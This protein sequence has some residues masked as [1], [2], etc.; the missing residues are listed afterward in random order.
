MGDLEVKMNR[1]QQAYDF[2]DYSR[3]PVSF[4]YC[5]AGFHKDGFKPVYIWTNEEFS[6]GTALLHDCSTNREIAVPLKPHGTNIWGRQDW[7]AD[8]S[9]VRREGE[10]TLKVRF[11]RHNA[12]TAPF[13]ISRDLYGDLR[14]KSAKHY[15]LKRC[16]IF[17]HTHDGYIYSLKPKSLG[18]VIRHI[19]ASGGWHD[20]HDDNKWTAYV[21][22]AVYG[23]LKTEESFSPRWTG[24]NGPY[25][26][27]LSEAWWEVDWL[28]KMQKPDGT[29]YTGVFEW[30]PYTKANRT[31]LR[32]HHLEQNYDDLHQDK[33]A[34]LDIWGKNAVV[35]ILGAPIYTFA[36]TAPKYFAYLA[37][38]L[39]YFG[40]L[41]QPY[42]SKNAKRCVNAAAKTINYLESMKR[43][44]PYQKLEVFAG[45]ALY[46]IEQAK[47]KRDAASI[48]KAEVSLEKML[49]LQQPEGYFHSSENC[50]GLEPFPEEAGD[51]RVFLDYPFGYMHALIEYLG[52]A[53]DK[54]RL[55]NLTD[56]VKESLYR[57]ARM[58][59]GFCRATVFRQPTEIRFDRT[60]SVIIPR[61]IA[62]HGYN[63]YILSAGTVFAAAER[64]AG[65]S[66][67][68][69]MAERQLQWV[70]GANPRF[71]SFMNQVGIRNSGQYAAASSVSYR[72]YSSAF[73]RH[74]R[75][76][77][78]GVTTGIYGGLDKELNDGIKRDL[79]YP[80]PENYP[81]AGNSMNGRYD[82]LAQETWLNCNGWMLLLLSYLQR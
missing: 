1:K 27:C 19:P 80:Q 71:M 39:R 47:E 61:A 78:W 73:Y 5:Q 3:K 2:D 18:K 13:A 75:D 74:L 34:V 16:G 21:W 52:Y 56:K 70:L 68:L 53:Q 67:G 24:N 20:A 81:N 8:S 79:L 66:G 65:Y 44:P 15:Y 6:G 57:F 72:Y 40:R 76:M 36:S 49:A 17:C 23:L 22:A 42:D 32:I 41:L 58:L 55:C 31:M 33:R 25:P 37:H 28:L 63:P 59:E 51:E 26:Y 11:G 30:F 43:Y 50:R 69:Q 46:Y 48:R 14:E 10:Y 35:K 45:M 12:E 29:F 9:A 77:R 64:L 82:H 4:Y 60:P 38:I 7:T 62:R 54:K